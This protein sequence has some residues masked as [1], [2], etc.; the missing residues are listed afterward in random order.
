MKFGRNKVIAFDFDE[1]VNF[2]GDTGPY[3]QYSL[4]RAGNIFK[5]LEERGIASEVSAEGLRGQG[6]GG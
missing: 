6:L 5:K 1:A 3:L 2:E 4:V